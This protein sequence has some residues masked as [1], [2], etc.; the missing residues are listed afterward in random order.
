[1]TYKSIVSRLG[2]K[3]LSRYNL[4]RIILIG[5]LA[6]A[7]VKS[8]IAS[9]TLIIN[10]IEW[11]RRVPFAPYEEKLKYRTCPEFYD[12]IKFIQ[13]NTSEDAVIMIPPQGSAWP[14]SGHIEYVQYFLYPRRLIKDDR[15]RILTE[16][17]ITH[18]FINWGE[19]GVADERIHGYPKYYVP[20]KK[21]ITMSGERASY[22]ASSPYL[23]RY[24]L[25]EVER[26]ESEQESLAGISPGTA[27]Y[28]FYRAQFLRARGEFKEVISELQKAA[29]IKPDYAWI[30][31]LLGDTWEKLGRHDLAIAYYQRAISLSPEV[32]WFYYTLGR[33]YEEEG[34][35]DEAVNIYKKSL[36]VSP[37]S[38]WSSFALGRIYEQK[39]K[40]VDAYLSFEKTNFLGWGPNT[41]DSKKGLEEVEELEKNYSDLL[42]KVKKE[43]EVRLEEE[44]KAD[45]EEIDDFES[46]TTGVPTGELK[47]VPGVEGQGVILSAS[48]SNIA[49][50][51]AEFS[52]QE[53]S[54]EFFW[55]PP[56]NI[57]QLPDEEMID[58]LHQLGHWLKQD[59]TLYLWAGKNYLGFGMFGQDERKW[60]FLASEK[61]QWN[62]QKWYRL[63]ISFGQK[64]MKL[65]IDGKFQAGNSFQKKSSSAIVFLGG[66][67]EISLFDFP[68]LTSIGYGSFDELTYYDEYQK[69]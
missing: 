40:L 63:T 58:L 41:L 10:E 48:G 42:E 53:G 31:Y 20:V 43:T 7:V 3:N 45:F 21:I 17:S 29:R 6:W 62:P 47:F 37:D 39:G 66:G 24:G 50:P 67:R 46:K 5:I 33:I 19:A 64:G 32:G 34:R 11:I 13:R 8:L 15:E 55:R 38:I 51:L 69:E 26:G 27:E 68:K 30:Y 16:S 25:I 44:K 49:Y 28:Y 61:F 52:P 2:K 12:F 14:F 35:Q 23:E 65:F 36:E 57:N 54:I 9:R 56:E 60:H 4:R 1:V 18:I 22:P 59:G